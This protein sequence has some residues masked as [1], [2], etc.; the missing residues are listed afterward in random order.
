[1]GCF[2]TIRRCGIGPYGNGTHLRCAV[3]LSEI[4]R[5]LSLGSRVCGGEYQ[6]S[7]VK[8]KRLS[9]GT[10]CKSILGLDSS[11]NS[12]KRTLV[13]L[14]FLRFCSEFLGIYDHF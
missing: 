2:L 5:A 10:K 3:W 11:L 8:S 4:R 9:H 1:M 12:K 7:M 6:K 14:G 13:S